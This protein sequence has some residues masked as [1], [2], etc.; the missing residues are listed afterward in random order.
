MTQ[1]TIFTKKFNWFLAGR[2]CFSAIEAIMSVAFA[3]HLYE[4]TKNPFDLALVGLFQILPVYLLFPVTGWVIDNVSRTKILVTGASAQAVVMVCLSLLMVDMHFNKWLA[5]CLMSVYGIGKAFMSPAL[6]ATVPNL[7][8]NYQLNKA[9]TITS[10][11]WNIAMTIGPFIAGVLI[12]LLD[13]QVY[14]FLVVGGCTTLLCFLQIPTIQSA[15]KSAK[16][17]LLGGLRFLK[18]NQIV[19]ASLSLDLLIVFFGSVMALLPVY[20]ADVL[21]VGPEGLGILR[22]MPAI[23]AVLT[24]IYL[25]KFKTEFNETGKALFVS[26]FIFAVSVVVFSLANTLWLASLALFVY[27]ASDMVS[28]VIRGAV[29]QHNTPDQLRGRVSAAN[30]IFIATSNQLGDFRAGAVAAILGPVGAALLGGCCAMTV[31]IGGAAYF[32]DLR[33]LKSTQK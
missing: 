19:M 26:L 33:N 20:A 16:R 2:G 6:Q 23:G 4:L 18:A 3:W 32:K 9:I 22:A 31:A 29:V 15:S 10:T 8:P 7:V 5:L 11:V 25:S 13:R 28:V 14:W 30:S 1:K 12:A 27:G 24:G 21:Q 17:D